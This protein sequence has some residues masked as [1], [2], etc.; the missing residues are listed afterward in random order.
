M[1]A[2]WLAKKHGQNSIQKGCPAAAKPL[3]KNT[4]LSGDAVILYKNI[5]QRTQLN[6]HLRTQ[7]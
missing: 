6:E 2:K 1:F 3:A 7:V 5:A 4:R